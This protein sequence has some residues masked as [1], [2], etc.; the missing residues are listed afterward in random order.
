LFAHTRYQHLVPEIARRVREKRPGSHGRFYTAQVAPITKEQKASEERDKAMSRIPA[1][2]IFEGNREPKKDDRIIFLG[3]SECPLL[4]T[5]RLSFNQND[6]WRYGEDTKG[7]LQKETAPSRMLGKRFYTMSKVKEANIIGIVVGTMSAT[8]YLDVIKHVQDVIR[9]A[10]KKSYLILV[11]KINVPK[12]SNFAEI[13]QFVFVACPFQSMVDDE[14]YFVSIATPLEAELALVRGREWT[15]DYSTDFR[16][17]I[18]DQG[19]L[20]STSEHKTK[21]ADDDEAAGVRF[22]LITRKVEPAIGRSDQ[23]DAAGAGAVVKSSSALTVKTSSDYML[24]R[25]FK[26]L[27]ATERPD[28]AP[29]QIEPGLFGIASKYAFESS[30][31]GRNGRDLDAGN[32]APVEKDSKSSVQEETP[33]DVAPARRLVRKRTPAEIKAMLLRKKKE[34]DEDDDDEEEEEED[35]DEDDE[36]ESQE[37]RLDSILALMTGPSKQDK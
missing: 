13:D 4:T 17:I 27:D 6:V 15:G 26:G 18:P 11:G 1:G 36:E 34:E 22:S 12:L 25:T 14:D 3:P 23:A 21:P 35:E 7:A 31:A 24:T 20:Q 2:Y 32:E 30:G 28:E 37:A 8:R 19:R 9:K 5:I 29:A 16:D 33:T 10:N